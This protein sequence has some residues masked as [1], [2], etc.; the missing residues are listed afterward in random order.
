ME[1]LFWRHQSKSQKKLGTCTIYCRL[2]IN[3]ERS[4]IGSTNIEVPIDD[5]DTKRQ[6]I[7]THNPNF[8]QLNLRLQEEF[9]SPILSI[10]T[11]L[12]LKRK[13]ITSDAIKRALLKVDV[14][15][16]TLIDAYEK[17]IADFKL[18]TK[19][20]T[21]K[22]GKKKEP[23]RSESTIRPLN[24]CRNKLLTYLIKNKEQHITIEELN[25]NWFDAYENWLYEINHEQSTIVKHQSVLK[26]VTKWA[27]SKKK[28]TSFDPF[29]YCEVEK[30]EQKDPNFL[31]EEQF[32]VW[33][34]HKF[35]SKM[36]QEVA[37]IFAVYCR[38]GF[39]YTDL[40]QVIENPSQYIKNGLDGKKWIYKPREKTEVVAKVPIT[41]FNEIAKVVDKYGGWEK[42]PIKQNHHLNQWLKICV[43]DINLHLPE[44]KRSRLKS[45][46]GTVFNFRLQ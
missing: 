9:K 4:D 38:T 2:T 37:D 45:N 33:I 16:M 15:L 5:F 46:F 20:Q 8:A 39:H 7:T 22:K 40:K 31:T 13:P 43:A 41:A 10:Y 18:K 1:I 34:S 25:E 3:G 17:Y 26:R 32:Q 29:Q 23:R 28:F 35:S 24:T 12:L 14:P 11:D 42:L 21:D 27:F 44:E 19:P 30:E 36:A 6:E